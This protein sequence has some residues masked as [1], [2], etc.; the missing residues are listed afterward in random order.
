MASTELTHHGLYI[1]FGR[2]ILAVTA[3]CVLNGAVNNSDYIIT[4]MVGLLISNDK[5]TVLRKVTM[6]K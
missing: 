2:Q 5:E 1:P 6:T 4:Q 3:F